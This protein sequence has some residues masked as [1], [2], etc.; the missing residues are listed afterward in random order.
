MLH[1]ILVVICGWHLWN[2]LL[3]SVGI[4]DNHVWP[5]S[6]FCFFVFILVYTANRRWGH[7]KCKGRNRCGSELKQV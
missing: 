3:G 5:N 1:K 6:F 2:C 7:R 4:G